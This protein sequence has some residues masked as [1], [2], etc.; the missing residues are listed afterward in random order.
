[1]IN[2]K[3]PVHQLNRKQFADALQKGLGRAYLH[4]TRFGIDDVSDLIL[5]ACSN[6]QSCDPQIEPSKAEYLFGMFYNAKYFPVFKEKILNSLNTKRDTWDLQ[7][8]LEIALK[9]AKAGDQKAKTA[10]KKK[11]FSIAG[12]HY[13][14]NPD[15]VNDSWLGALEWITLA[16][17][18]GA[19]D[20]ARVYGARLLKYPEEWVPEDEIFPDDKIKKEFQTKIIEGSFK[21]P[22]LAAYW[23]YLE[24]QGIFRPHEGPHISQEM[25]RD[26]RKQEER[27]RLNLVKIISDA[28]NKFDEYGFRFV[29]FGRVATPE[30]LTTLHNVML[31]E[32]DNAVIWRFLRV[33]SLVPLPRLDDK[34]FQWAYSDDDH[35]RSAAIHALSHSNDVKVH[36]LA[37]SKIQNSKLKGS[38]SG[39]I[40]LFINNYEL[41]DT[42]LIKRALG[43]IKPHGNT[44]HE[45][46]W[47]II[48]LCEKN[49]DK[50]L[51]YTLKWAYEN[52]PCSNCRFTIVK[53][54]DSLGELKGRILYECR[55]DS[56]E[57]IVDLARKKP[58]N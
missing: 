48:D 12:K 37:R 33:F 13:K 21:E 58:L 1:L 4:A 42:R 10:I 24:K 6:N 15:K 20:L 51:V 16:G 52:T 8:I 54:L 22:E 43:Q 29:R 7:L 2:K 17:T 44:A 19:M 38:D 11:A 26:R 57:D 41:A 40:E 53:L 9:M 23:A 47:D 3:Y 50:H 14:T 34:V 35:I 46:A 31:N 30:E 28:K 39:I 5:K 49:H 45:I 56:N 27:Q 18:E 25:A 32:T 55:F 36:M